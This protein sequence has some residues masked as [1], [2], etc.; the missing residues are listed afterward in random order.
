MGWWELTMPITPFLSGQ[1]FEPATVA[2]MCAAFV[3]ACRALA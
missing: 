2:A 3:D 1:E